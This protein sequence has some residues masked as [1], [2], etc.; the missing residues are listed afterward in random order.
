MGDLII[1]NQSTGESVAPCFVTLFDH[2]KFP[3]IS[4]GGET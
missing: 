1:G 3:S 4:F 2:K